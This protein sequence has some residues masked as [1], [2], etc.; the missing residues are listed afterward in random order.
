MS[1]FLN[2][3]YDEDDALLTRIIKDL[4]HNEA[5]I[6]LHKIDDYESV[7]DSINNFNEQLEYC[8][9]LYQEHVHT[10]KQLMMHINEQMEDDRVSKLLWRCVKFNEQLYSHA[11]TV[12]DGEFTN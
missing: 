10:L 1:E 5:N 11:Y 12:A 4:R 2:Q 8:S 6:L 7:N 3:V 9:T